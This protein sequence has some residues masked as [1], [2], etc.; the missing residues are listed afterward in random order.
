M[1]FGSGGGLE[2]CVSVVLDMKNS[3]LSAGWGRLSGT[4]SCRR[5]SEGQ[6]ELPSVL[7]RVLG[8]NLQE[9]HAVIPELTYAVLLA[10]L[11]K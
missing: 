4:P 3:Q 8:G 7:R 2:L 10:H 6:P 9:G 1:L 11:Q 5:E